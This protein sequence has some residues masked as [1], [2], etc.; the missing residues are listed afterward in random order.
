VSVESGSRTELRYWRWALFALALWIAAYMVLADPMN[1]RHR[2]QGEHD[3]NVT[4]LGT[5]ATNAAEA[6]ATQWFQWLAIDDGALAFTFHIL[7]SQDAE[8][9]VSDIA[10]SAMS[11]G[12]NRVFAPIQGW[13]DSRLQVGWAMFYQCLI[14]LSVSILWWP[15][16]LV[17]LLP[18]MI[19][20]I[21]IRRITANNFGLTS[22]HGYVLGRRIIFGLPLLFALT[23]L[24]PMALP[25]AVIP[26]ICMAFAWACWAAIVNF[27]KRA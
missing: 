3:S 22:P 25:A 18:F 13:V 21:V 2:I 5:S 24:V 10:P 16:F 14:R 15:F 23:L 4:F 27:A 6:R 8:E 12:V 20:A 19:D 1:L 9:N 11:Q 7:G 26:V 17:V